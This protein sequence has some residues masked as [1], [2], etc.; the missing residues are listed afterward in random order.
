MFSDDFCS[1]NFDKQSGFV[2]FSELINN[3]DESVEEKPED[4][5]IRKSKKPKI[6]I[7]VMTQETPNRNPLALINELR[8]DSKWQFTDEI[9]GKFGTS[10]KVE[11]KVGTH[12]FSGVGKTKKLAKYV[13]AKEAL[14]D[15]FGI[16]CSEIIAEP[17]K[18][19]V[20]EPNDTLILDQK[21][22]DMIG[23]EVLNAAKL[24]FEQLGDF[25]KW[26]VLSSIVLTSDYDPNWLDIICL[27]TGTKC[28]KGDRLSMTGA[29]VHDSHA[30]VL[31]RR[32]FILYLYRQLLSIIDNNYQGLYQN[33]QVIAKI[34]LIN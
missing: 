16:N 30:E 3:E 20:V 4:E 11:L 21:T 7:R 24:V 28:I 15:L 31:S 13:A 19:I 27:T 25:K 26:N 32:C 22:A 34:L 8:P 17:T 29:T 1:D 23:F 18:T 6:M 9:P 33:Q 14:K 12:S 10:F 2:K 5:P